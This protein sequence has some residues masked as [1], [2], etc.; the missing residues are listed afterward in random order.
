MYDPHQHSS[1]DHF[2]SR[3]FDVV[4]GTQHGLD[5]LFHQAGIMCFI[6]RNFEGDHRPFLRHGPRMDVING[7]HALYILQQVF[8][9]LSPIDPPLCQGCCP[10]L[11]FSLIFRWAG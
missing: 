8:S 7:R 1:L 11:Y 9:N 4:F 10:L 3:M 2:D 6:D 5:L